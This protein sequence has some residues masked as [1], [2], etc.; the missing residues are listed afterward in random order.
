MSKR[1]VTVA[2][3]VLVAGIG[4]YAV[5]LAAKPPVAAASATTVIAAMANRLFITDPRS[6]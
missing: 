6:P 2:A 5:F 1:I 3:V 4:G